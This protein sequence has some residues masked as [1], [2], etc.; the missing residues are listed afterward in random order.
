MRPSTVPKFGTDVKECLSAMERCFGTRNHEACLVEAKREANS[1]IDKLAQE[2]AFIHA[3]LEGLAAIDEDDRNLVG[4]LAA[5]L[6]VA[7]DVDLPPGEATA[8]FEF[9]QCLLDD[10][11]QMAALAGIDDD[12]ASFRHEVRFYRFSGGVS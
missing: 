10:F 11:T 8:A 2:F 4:K 3:V 12:F 6:F 5:Q 7:V 1:S 9:A